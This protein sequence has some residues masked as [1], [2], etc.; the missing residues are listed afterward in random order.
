MCVLLILGRFYR[1]VEG[2]RHSEGFLRRSMAEKEK[3]GGLEFVAGK[4]SFVAT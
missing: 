1:N 2:P 4:L 3:S